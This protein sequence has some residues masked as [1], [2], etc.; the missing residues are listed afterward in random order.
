MSLY[1]DYQSSRRAELYGLLGV[2]PDREAPVTVTHTSREVRERNGQ[3]IVLERLVLHV[4]TDAD[5]MNEP[6]PAWYA[7]LEGTQPERKLPCLSTVSY[8]RTAH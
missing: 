1:T 4:D 6:I 2:L 7:V 3:R 5:V 8:S